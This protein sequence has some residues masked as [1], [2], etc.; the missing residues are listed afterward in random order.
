MR[1]GRDLA[2]ALDRHAVARDRLVLHHERD[3]PALGTV[4]LHAAEDVDALELL[5]ER[6]RPAEAGRDRVGVGPDVVAVQRVA[7][8]EAQRVARAEPARDDAAREHGVPERDG[9]V[10]HAQELAAVLAG[11]AGAVDHHL[12][13]VDRRL[14]EGER[15][16]RRQ[17]EPLDR[18][19][20]LHGDERVLVGDVAHV[21]AGDL[22][23]LQP[24]EVGL[25]VR[26]VDDEEI[27]ALVEPVDDEV[28]DDAAVLVREQR[29][30]RL[31]GREL[32]DVVR[33]R[34][35]QEVAG[36]RPFDLELA[37]V[38]DVEHAGVGPHGAVLVDDAGVLHRHLP[39]RERDHLR[40]E[41]DVPVVER[42]VEKRLGH[43]H[44]RS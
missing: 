4:L 8:L 29:V 14:G 40:A 41:L 42:R 35:L 22:A 9:V 15:R 20:A 19:R 33:E 24:R 39:A 18:A 43:G 36:A 6:A 7:D 21:G 27:G 38:R 17:P 34:R 5:V 10:G 16:R 1:A 2:A 11:V 25:A 12:D 44:G 26:G 37:H 28:V 3:E 30:L 13:A 31:A 32:V 23:L